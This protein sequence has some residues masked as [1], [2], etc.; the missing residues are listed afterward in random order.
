MTGARVVV[1]GGG[2][3]GLVAACYLAR[4]GADV[5]VLEQA[6]RLGGGLRT[7]EVVPGHRFHLHSVA[8]DIVQATGI[9]GDLRLHE[10]GLEYREMDSFSVAV[11]RD[12]P[13][14]RSVRSVDPVLPG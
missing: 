2:H 1:V 3:N 11:L 7:D 14:V 9:V 10:A 12:G 6:D 13:I 8:H 5:L 4:A